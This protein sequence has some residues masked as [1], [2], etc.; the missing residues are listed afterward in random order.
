MD[1]GSNVLDVSVTMTAVVE[2]DWG[3]GGSCV[4][5]V[6]GGGVTMVVDVELGGTEVGGALVG[7]LEVG[8]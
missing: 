3:G 4:V 6:D 2:V 5:L 1:V 8:G 7:G